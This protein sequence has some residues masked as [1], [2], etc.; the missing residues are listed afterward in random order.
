MV[1]LGKH[2]FT[3]LQGE[4]R[5][6]EP[7]SAH[8]TW[9]VG[10]PADCYYKPVG[11]DDLAVFLSQLPADEPLFWLGLG[12]NV[13]VRDG[14]LRG[15]VIAYFGGLNEI[16]QLADGSVKVEAGVACAKVARFC[17]KQGL[18]GAEFLSGI[19]GAVGGAL[20]MNAGAFGGETWRLVERVEVMQRDGKRL[21]R[22]AA[23]YEV[24]YRTVVAPEDN[25]WF[26]AAWLSLREGD[27]SETMNNIRQLLARRSAMQPTQLANAGSVFRNP[28]ADYAAR[29]IEACGLKGRSIGGAVVSEKHANFIVNS[30]EASATDIEQLINEVM[31]TVKQ[32]QGVELKKEVHLI[33]VE[34]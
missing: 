23:E 13:L 31:Q 30:G 7:M 21:I 20:A 9:R 34:Q 16:A 3:G 11:I 12:S 10:G 32:K 19:P 1:A 15:T 33:G 5:F 17:A 28:P 2:Y 27:S 6:N 4:L 18:V 25:E 22:D 26:V 29:L 8:T 24:G 14:G